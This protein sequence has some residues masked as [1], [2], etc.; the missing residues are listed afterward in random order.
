MQF[1][2][3]TNRTADTERRRRLFLGYAIGLVVVGTMLT[4]LAI[5][6][7]AEL[8]QEAEENVLEV[9]LA[10]EPE[11]EPEEEIEPEPEP[12][13]IE[14]DPTPSQPQPAGPILPDL[15]APDE[16]PDD[17]PEEKEAVDNPYAAADP[18]A[19]GAG[20]RG[21][22]PR[23]TKKVVKAAPPP[24]APVAPSPSGPVRVTA[25]TVPPQKIA[26]VGAVYPESAKAAGI[27]GA[28]IV[29]FVVDIAGN[30]TNVQAVR[31]PEALRPACEAS[32]KSQKFT[33]ARSKATG[34][35]ISVTKLKKCTFKLTT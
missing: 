31:G 4:A 10:E 35:A 32:V 11:S 7:P 1:D 9:A 6:K 23:N 34:E 28:V 26:G 2:S 19:Y 25:D 21:T 30:V 33:P 20:Q 8:P 12:E 29:K 24:P 17:A 14:P 3:W 22:A 16:I 18:Y 27:E 5:A 13:P 15:V